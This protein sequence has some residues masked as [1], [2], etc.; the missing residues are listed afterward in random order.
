MEY[1][2]TFDE[3]LAVASAISLKIRDL[4]EN[5]EQCRP[6]GLDSH[7]LVQIRESLMSSYRKIVGVAYKL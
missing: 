7:V 2:L 4:T 3:E 5:I 1:K 6:L